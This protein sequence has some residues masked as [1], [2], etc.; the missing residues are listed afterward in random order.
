MKSSRNGLSTF[1][2]WRLRHHGLA[3]GLQRIH[4]DDANDPIPDAAG[5]FER[6]RR[7]HRV[8]HENHLRVLDL[9]HDR[10]DVFTEVAHRPVG[11]IRAEAPWPARSTT[12]V[13]YFD[14]SASICSFQ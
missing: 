7:A 4:R 2:I 6:N 12:T 9:A 10:R 8:A 11:A 1:S 3:D 5:R 14:F 13:V